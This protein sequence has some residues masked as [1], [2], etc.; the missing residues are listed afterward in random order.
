MNFLEAFDKLDRIALQERGDGGQRTYKQFLL[1][2]AK[3]L[4][5]KVPADY[6]SNWVLHHKDCDH[7]NNEEF[8][9]LVLMNPSHHIS[10]HKQLPEGATKTDMDDLLKNGTMKN[11]DKFAYWAIGE[12][13]HARINQVET[14]PTISEIVR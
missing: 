3:F 2:L 4:G 10:F 8:A 13:I 6:K 9:N 12:E 14:E 11:G 1:Y 7:D 5:C